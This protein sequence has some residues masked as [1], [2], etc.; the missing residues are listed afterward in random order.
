MEVEQSRRYDLPFSLIIF[1]VDFFKNYNDNNG[2]I[3][4]ST[5][6]CRIGEL[7]KGVFRAADILAKYGGDEFVVILPNTDRVG[8]FLAADRLRE[9]VESEP[10]IG[11]E[12][13][14]SGHLTLS[15]GLASFPEH[16]AS[17]EN[18][19]EHADKALYL[20]KEKGRNRVVI[21]GE[22]QAAEDGQ[23]KLI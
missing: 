13:Q 17:G 3:R 8:A 18:I 10:F 4:G 22:D 20:A 21:F 23:K 11:S 2:H 7:M 19:L 16:G 9:T 6:L 15:L 1:D 14:P 12:K 5:A